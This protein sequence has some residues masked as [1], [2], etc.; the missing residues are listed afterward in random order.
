MTFSGK[1]PGQ[2]KHRTQLLL[3]KNGQKH[4]VNK[5]MSDPKTTFF[6]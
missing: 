3:D 2:Y 1:P 6:G 5:G 4:R